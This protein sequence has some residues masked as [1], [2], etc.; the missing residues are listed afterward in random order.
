MTYPIE[1]DIFNEKLNKKK[2][3]SA[4]VIEEE[5]SVVEGIFEGYLK[6]D[7]VNI[8]SISIHTE[9]DFA[10]EKVENYFVSIPSETPWKTF[11]KVFAN[12]PVVYCIYETT[13]DQVEAEDV[14]VLQDAITNTQTEIE[15]YKARGIIDGGKF[16][17]EG[18]E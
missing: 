15:R 6:H 12:T 16:I 5:L 2:D 7:N 4:Y 8:E 13:G 11:L 1:V 14:N 10:G 18:V 9:P 17:R 3:G